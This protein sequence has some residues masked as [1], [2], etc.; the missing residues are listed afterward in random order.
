M[1]A[2][3]LSYLKKQ[4]II[5]SISE[6]KNHKCY[7]EWQAYKPLITSPIH[8]KTYTHNRLLPKELKKS[9]LEC[10]SFEENATVYWLI[11]NDAPIV[12][13]SGKALYHYL[14]PQKHNISC[15]DE[16][17]KMRSIEVFLEEI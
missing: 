15:L 13:Q 16:G 10:Y 12:S 2:E 14:T 5:A 9:K 4:A 17:A 1:R 7:Q 11:D 3:V 6:L 8:T